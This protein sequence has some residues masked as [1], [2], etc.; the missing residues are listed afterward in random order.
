ME[1]RIIDAYNWHTYSVYNT[2][3]NVIAYRPFIADVVSEA[4]KYGMFDKQLWTSETGL[5]I[6]FSDTTNWELTYTEHKPQA[7]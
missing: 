2:N 6:P 3:T 5:Q 7:R 4:H 1:L